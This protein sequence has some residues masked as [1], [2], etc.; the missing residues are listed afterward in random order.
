MQTSTPKGLLGPKLV[1][2][3]LMWGVES[4]N[5]IQNHFFPFTTCRHVQVQPSNTLAICIH[6]NH[7]IACHTSENQIPCLCDL[8][9]PTPVRHTAQN[10]MS[11]I[12]KG[13]YRI[14]DGQLHKPNMYNTGTY[15]WPGPHRQS[16]GTI[17]SI[18]LGLN[19]NQT[20][21]NNVMTYVLVLSAKI[22]R[23]EWLK[24]II[25]MSSYGKL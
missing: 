8:H 11:N 6:C 13:M 20:R 22:R 5:M 10:L 16:I 1:F 17:I 23:N 2:W 12:S 9:L 19:F 21:T 25:Q 18:R 15:S 24:L 3:K 4:P 14:N 7:P